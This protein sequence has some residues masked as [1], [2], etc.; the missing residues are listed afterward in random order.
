MLHPSV[1]DSS[2]YI[3]SVGIV[4]AITTV[5]AVLFSFLIRQLLRR[6]VQFRFGHKL[7]SVDPSNVS[8]EIIVLA[9]RRMG[10][11]FVALALFSGLVV[12]ASQYNR[13]AYNYEI[14]LYYISS[15]SAIMILY[16]ASVRG[17]SVWRADRL[18]ICPDLT[19]EHVSIF[20]TSKE[21]GTIMRVSDGI[22]IGKQ[23]EFVILEF[24]NGLKRCVV[25]P[26]KEIAELRL[27][28]K[29]S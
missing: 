20:G 26:P 13:Y 25:Y 9:G 3:I 18:F 7:R 11:E 10:I 19:V 12:W 22:Q 16:Y 15:P 29:A 14:A 23:S 6:Y 17:V 2:S 21:L 5:E 27:L 4:L 24:N 28:F 1:V 8:G